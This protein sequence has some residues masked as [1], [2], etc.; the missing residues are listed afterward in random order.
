[1]LH[2][3]R[4]DRSDALVAMLAELVEV[5]LDDPMAAEVVS[6]PTRGIE[7]WLTQRLSKHLG[8]SPG[9]HDGVCANIDFPFPGVLVT[10]ALA[11]ADGSDPESDP[12][13]PERAVWPLIE[14][15][16]ANFGESWLA[17]LA[18]HIE[19]SGT[20]EGSRRFSSI[21]HVADLFDRYAVHRPDML[22]RWAAGSPHLDEPAWQFELWGRLR[23][24][25]GTPSPAER[26]RDACQRLRQ[27]PELLDEPRRLSLFGLTRLP[28]SHLDV[29]QA[30]AHRRDVHLFVLHPSPALW[31]R[32]EP[33]VGPTSRTV[34]RNEDPTADEPRHPLLASWG[35]DA[36]ELQLVLGGAVPH[37]DPLTEDD[38]PSQPTL[39]QRIQADVRADRAPGSVAGSDDVPLLAES[40]DSI[41][42]HSCHGRGRQVEVL[43]DALLHLLED[44][45]TLEPRDIIVMCPDI[46]NFAPLIQATFGSHGVTGA[47]DDATQ[48]LQIRLA[49]RSLRQ[50]NPVMGVLAEVVELATA[51]ITATEVLDLAG[52]EPV[53]RRFRFGDEDLS[54]L[55]EWVD[56][57]GVRWGFDA[58]HRRSFQLEGV[59]ANTWRS[60]LDRILLGV[61]M[62]EEGQRLFCATLPLD[63]VDSA[64]IELAGRLA[65]FLERLRTALDLLAETRPMREWSDVLTRISDS[66]TST[67]SRDAWQRAELTTMLDQLVGEATLD[68]SV[69]PVDLGCD[70]LRSILTGRL[71]GKPTRANFCTGHLTVCTLVPMRSVPH[72]VVCLLG[73]DDGSF[74][75]HFERDGDDLTARDQRVGDHDVRSEDR[76]LLLDALLAA[77]ERLLV[78][79]SGR[80]ERSNL[81]RPPAVP[82][83]ELLDVVDRTVRTGSGRPRDAVVVRHPL[84]PFDQ[85][86]YVDGALVAGRPWSF[87]ALHLDGARAALAPRH[88]LAPFLAQPLPPDAADPL[89]LDRLEQF[90][91][92]PVR[93]FLRQRLDVSLTD[94]T[95]DF[96]DAIPIDL[97]AL[98]Q[99]QIADRILQA[100]L[101]H[102]PWEDCLQAELARG[103]LPPGELGKPE[104]LTIAADVDRLVVAGDSDV[105]P[106]SVDVHV[107][108]AGLPS[109]VGTVAGVRGDVVHTVTYSKLGPVQRLHAWLRLLALTATWPERPFEACTIGRY[110]G[111]R[112]LSVSVA[113]IGPLGPDPA[114]RR[115]T[116]E[117]QLRTLVDVY[118]RGMREALPLYCKTSGAWAGAVAAGDDPMRAARSKWDGGYR[119]PG[120]SEDDE[121][122]LV[123]GGKLDFADMAVRSGTPSSAELG[124]APGRAAATRFELYA[125][126]VWE[127]LL[128][129]EELVDR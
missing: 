4:S 78:T 12:W 48:R 103:E 5:P 74:P 101:R 34:T 31:D 124:D 106:V 94:R 105:A 102:V 73:L 16:E 95:R 104:L 100:R 54:R 71:R 72:R 22:Q 79:Y 81:S 50:T 123:L 42:V 59:A 67:S 2:V 82:V 64:D 19:K 35:R 37:G 6:V 44:D 36:R 32:L 43:R 10:R 70:D 58:E 77:R 61:T 76:Q 56:E 53:R 65:E 41:R 80:D 3:H 91:R 40:D 99:W 15:V 11:A 87:D 113:T 24:R 107:D 97:N 63:D 108:L 114:A 21:R 66:L 111:S 93:A 125:W 9:R 98:D 38:V 115:A 52:R 29:L 69:S 25:I 28:A 47:S 127:G 14:V 90:L 85:R 39:L 83:G 120:E 118:L 8:A 45:P 18:Q 96:D 122:L 30:V 20:A 17:P 1:V 128:A 26:S 117:A 75:R 121:H 68:G 92:H 109:L 89:G 7:R 51:R 112:S 33:V 88:E 46:E 13:Q 57:S 126:Q 23:E 116:A 129:H 86:N 60:G 110:G 55:E 27:H 84:Q 49:D 119:N 62:A